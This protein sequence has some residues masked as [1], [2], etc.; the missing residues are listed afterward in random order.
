MDLKVR[1]HKFLHLYSL[2]QWASKD[3]VLV[4]SRIQALLVTPPKERLNKVME[5][6]RLLRQGTGI[7]LWPRLVMVPTMDHHRLRNLRVVSPFM[8]KP[9]SH[10]APQEAMPSLHL[11]NLG[12]PILSRR[13]PNLVTLN[14]ILLPNGLQ[15]LVLA[16]P[17]LSL[18]MG[19]H[20]M[21]HRQGLSQLTGS[22]R[23]TAAL[24]V[25]VVI[26]SLQCILQRAILAQLLRVLNR[27][28]LPK[29]HPRVDRM[30]NQ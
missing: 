13:L 7:N 24:M 17:Q 12:I 10:L 26:R 2:L 4:S 15:L 9:S 14:Q 3:T 27:L 8:V 5:S 28:E 20:L 30:L 19:R 6:H 21:V 11:C 1:L 22:S 29:P 25:A 23:H 16:Q 18:D